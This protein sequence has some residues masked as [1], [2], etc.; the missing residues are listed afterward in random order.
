MTYVQITITLMDR[1]NKSTKNFARWRDFKMKLKINQD[2]L[3]LHRKTAGAN[4]QVSCGIWI[5][6]DI[7]LTSSWRNIF[8]TTQSNTWY[9]ESFYKWNFYNDCHSNIF[10]K[11]ANVDEIHLCLI[12]SPEE[13]EEIC[14]SQFSIIV[15]QMECPTFRVWK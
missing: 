4:D 15:H 10:A 8:G 14:P 3:R 13:Y 7:H 11:L 6:I 5:R 2:V 12:T 9:Q 1:W